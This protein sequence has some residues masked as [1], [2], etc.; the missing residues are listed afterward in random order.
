MSR[1]LL[2][3]GKRYSVKTFR[4]CRQETVDV[5]FDIKKKG[6]APQIRGKEC[7]EVFCNNSFRP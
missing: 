4:D 6:L 7:S 2:L 1:D 5:L 3:N